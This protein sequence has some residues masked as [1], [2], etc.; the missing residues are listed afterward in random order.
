MWI[1]LFMRRIKYFG[2]RLV[3]TPN[4]IYKTVLYIC[5]LLFLISLAIYLTPIKTLR[6][7]KIELSNDIYCYRNYELPTLPDV[8][9][10][11]PPKGRSIFF[12]ETS[13][14]SNE[15]QKII[16]TA[17]QAC[18][19]ESA[20]LLNPNFRVY[21]LFTSPA[22]IK[23]ENNE[24]DNIL[25]Q[26]MMYKNVRL[27]HLNF[28]RYINGSPIAELYSSLRIEASFYARSHASD[29]LRYLTLWRYGGI[30][31]D[32]DVILI[33]SLERL[34]PNYAGRESDEDVAAGVLSFSHKGDGHRWARQSLEDL[35]KNFDGWNW[36]NNGPG[37]I[38]R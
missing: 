5:M 15:E 4:L 22:A 29:V 11:D 32:L 8:L 19:V 30:Y 36:G 35:K 34:K 28:G 7:I 17:R 33:K 20:A 9:D 31:L 1:L 37:V 21:L 3:Y 23:L 13:C 27:K 18:A 12:H 10:D 25:K 2:A 16:I 14:T 26:L 38:T 24:N 6:K